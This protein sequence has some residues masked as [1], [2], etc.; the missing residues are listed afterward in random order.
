MKKRYESSATNSDVVMYSKATLMRDLAHVPY[1]I[2]MSEDIKRTVV[3]KVFACI[4]NSP[5]AQEFDLIN[6]S[7]ISKSQGFVLFG[8]RFDKRKLC[9]AKFFVPFVK[10]RR[11]MYIN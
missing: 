2:K 9:K 11:C 10:K 7:Y 3:K 8:K 1:P 6:T 5:L 4:K